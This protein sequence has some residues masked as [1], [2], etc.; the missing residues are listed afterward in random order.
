MAQV[1]A[2]GG[3]LSVEFGNGAHGSQCAVLSFFASLLNG[4]RRSGTGAFQFIGPA[5]M[6]ESLPH[7]L[8]N[9]LIPFNLFTKRSRWQS[10][11]DF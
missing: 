5:F 8:G 9:R 3:S 6:K 11:E 4:R 7:Q 10:S 1:E 2:G